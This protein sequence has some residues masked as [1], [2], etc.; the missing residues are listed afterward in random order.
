METITTQQ[1]TTTATNDQVATL[2][3]LLKDYICITTAEA[4]EIVESNV[5]ADVN[6]LVK[7]ANKCDHC[8]PKV[9]DAFKAVALQEEYADKYH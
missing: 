1:P 3:R 2:N 7:H 5:E 4:A 9:N 6:S 8:S